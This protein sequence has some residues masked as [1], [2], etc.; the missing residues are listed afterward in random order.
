MSPQWHLLAYTECHHSVTFESPL[1]FYNCIPVQR[2]RLRHF[3]VRRLS[4]SHHL[5]SLRILDHRIF[6]VH[7]NSLVTSQ[8]QAILHHAAELL[9]HPCMR[10]LCMTV[11][12]GMCS[13]NSIVVINDGIEFRTAASTSLVA[14]HQNRGIRTAWCSFQRMTASLLFSPL[15]V[16]SVLSSQGGRGHGAPPHGAPQNW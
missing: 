3:Q 12:A 13:H 2:A 8:T 16:F 7:A 5:H 6:G 11:I 1:A 9:C 4:V 14:T 15:L 10:T